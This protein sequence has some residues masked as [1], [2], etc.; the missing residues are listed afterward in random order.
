MLP[1]RDAVLLAR[2]GIGLLDDGRHHRQIAL[3]GSG[4]CEQDQH[5][6]DIELSELRIGDEAEGHRLGGADVLHGDEPFVPLLGDVR[7]AIQ[8]LYG[9]PGIPVL[10][11]RHGDLPQGVLRTGI[12]HQSLLGA[13]L[14]DVEQLVLRVAVE[15]DDVAAPEGGSG[16]F[17]EIWLQERLRDHDEGHRGGLVG[18]GARQLIDEIR[19]PLLQKDVG[20]VEDHQ[21]PPAACGQMLSERTGHLVG[22]ESSR[23]EPLVEA[24]DQLEQ[25]TG[26]RDV[27]AVHVD[28][29]DGPALAGHVVGQVLGEPPGGDRLPRSYPSVEGCGAGPVLHRE[30][31]EQGLQSR[32]LR[33]PPDDAFRNIGVVQGLAVAY[34]DGASVEHLGSCCSG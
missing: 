12:G 32:D 30:R 8:E 10:G 29:G 3:H 18:P 20:L 1:R 13:C 28:D 34:D 22:G 5:P 4:D 25:D 15:A 16:G 9:H 31:T 2:D 7:G 27:P 24:S 21:H 23:R 6:V 26:L 11:G 17:V 33:F 14:H 19:G